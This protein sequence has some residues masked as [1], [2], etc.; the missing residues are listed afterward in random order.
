MPGPDQRP[1][2]VALSND[3]ELLLAGMKAVL[4]P[5]ADRVQVVDM[6]TTD[7]LSA[8][9]DVI[10]FDTFGRLS[11]HDHKLQ[12]FLHETSARV[13]VY[14]WDLF[15]ADRAVEQ[16]AAGY[17]FKGVSAGELVEAIEAVHAGGTVIPPESEPTGEHV[18]DDWPGR[19][20][21]L[22]ARESE[23]LALVTQGYTNQEIA[24]G[25]FLSINTVKTYLRLAYRKIGVSRRSQAVAWGIDHGLRPAE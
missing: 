7:Q 11:E 13:L 20:E 6:T 12:S 9:A 19:A 22:T 8:E 4:E 2:R 24:S 21:G 18:A 1:V 14:S 15:P 17:V 16:G 5:Y 3:F 25:V 10:L 23:I